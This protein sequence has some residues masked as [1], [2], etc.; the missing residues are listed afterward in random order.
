MKIYMTT[1]QISGKLKRYKDIPLCFRIDNELV[2]A[3]IKGSF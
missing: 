2:I 3:D 1:S